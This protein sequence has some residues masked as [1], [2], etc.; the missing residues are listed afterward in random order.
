MSR[1][2]ATFLT[3]IANPEMEERKRIGVRI[4][5]FL[6]GMTAVTYVVKRQIWADVH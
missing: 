3:Y 2:V 6:A 4:V 1:D 5:L